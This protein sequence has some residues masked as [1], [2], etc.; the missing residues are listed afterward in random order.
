[1]EL[2]GSRLPFS[3]EK[4]HA[5]YETHDVYVAKVQRAATEA[6]DAGV[7]LQGAAEG[8]IALAEEAAVP[9]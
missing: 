6:V 2:L 3:R 9:E 1:M 8:M 5:L 4:L 7:I